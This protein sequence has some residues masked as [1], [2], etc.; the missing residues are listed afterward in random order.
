M[1]RLA[2]AL[3]LLAAPVW[4]TQDSWPALY[5]VSGVQA[6]D[7]LNLRANP[8]A[9]AEIVGTLPHDAT[10]IEVIRPSDSLGWGLVN[11]AER[12]GWLSLAFLQR[13]PEQWAGSMPNVRQCFGTE[14]FWSIKL[15]DTAIL[16]SMPDR[17]D[18]AGLI[19]ARYRS[20]SR[21]DR[22]VYGGAL[23][24]EGSEGQNA[25]LSI[26]LEACND[27]MSDRA[28]GIGL[29]MLLTGAA[30]PTE[31]VLFSGCCTLSP[32]NR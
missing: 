15:G 1:I 27:G 30:N 13:Q 24:S 32:S 6:D 26:R 11:T 12:T 16:L 18:R 5:D 23:I 22:F 21:L 20:Q 19:S 29:D 4:A 31:N 10:N 17:A 7:V 2:L 28:Y 25:L 14:P 3:W 9:S 8:T